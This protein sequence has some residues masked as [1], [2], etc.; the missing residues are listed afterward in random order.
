MCKNFQKQFYKQPIVMQCERCTHMTT[1]SIH[2]GF[3]FVYTCTQVQ[4]TLWDGYNVQYKQV[5]VIYC[6]M[7]SPTNILT[8]H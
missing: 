4:S 7:I 5:H 1:N 2:V 8:L 6:N 3:I